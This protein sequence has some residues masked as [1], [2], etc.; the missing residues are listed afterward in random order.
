MEESHAKPS[1][2]T[3]ESTRSLQPICLGMMLYALVCLTCFWS[4]P[5][6]ASLLNPLQTRIILPKNVKWTSSSSDPKHSVEMATLYGDL[7]KAG[8]YCVLVKWYPGYMSAPHSYATDRLSIVVSGTWCVNSGN[9]FDPNHCIPVPAGGFVKRAAHTPHYDGVKKNA[10]K[11]A[12]IAIFGIGP[13][14]FKRVDPTKPSWR[15]L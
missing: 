14:N 13:V 5:A 4:I 9:D 7:N 2:F 6:K 3:S 12:I 15:K 8:P 11:P 1:T 10:K